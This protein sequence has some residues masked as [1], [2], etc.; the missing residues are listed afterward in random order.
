MVWGSV[1]G[2]LKQDNHDPIKCG[3]SVWKEGGSVS[4]KSPYR[5]KSGGFDNVTFHSKA[6]FW[7]WFLSNNKK[8]TGLTLFYDFVDVG[9]WNWIIHDDEFDYFSELFM[10]YKMSQEG[11]VSL[12]MTLGTLTTRDIELLFILASELYRAVVEKTRV[13][14]EKKEK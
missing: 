11:N 7:E 3:C 5:L 10:A 12:E 14:K 13:D 6:D 9:C 1:F 8:S 2:F 4:I